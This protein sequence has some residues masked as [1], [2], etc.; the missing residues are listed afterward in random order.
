MNNQQNTFNN[1]PQIGQPLIPSPPPMPMTR[2][3]RLGVK[4]MSGK[5]LGYTSLPDW[6]AAY[7]VSAYALTLIG[8][9]LVYS[10]YAMEWY[11]WLFG[12]VW[13]AGFF[14][15][16]VKFNN[17]WSAR[18]L[19]NSK[20]FEKKIFGTGLAL[21][22]VYAIF[23]YY[24]YTN[25]TGRPHE[26][27]AADSSEYVVTA[28]WFLEE[29]RA[30]RF[31]AMLTEMSRSAMGDMGYPLCLM[32]P[33]SIVGDEGAVWFIQVIQAVVGAYTA[34]LVY[35]L[36]KRSMGEDVAR[37]AAIFCM[38][39]PILICYIGMTLKETIM[40]CLVVL[41][42]EMGDRMLRKRNY[43]FI[44]IAPLVLVGLSL[45]LFRTVIGMIVFMALFF[46]LV[47]MDSRIV[48]WGKKIA[49]GIM[50]TGVLFMAASESIIN[51]ID[52]INFDEAQSQQETSLE[53]RYGEKKSGGRGN[54]FA[55][56]AGTAVFAPLIFTI[57]F[58][59]MV[60]TEGQEDMRLIHGGN[61]MRN[62]TSGLVI[63]AMFMLLLTGDWRKFTL[64]LAMLL[65]Y[66]MMLSF[67]QFAHSLRFHIP[68]M[69][70]EMMFAAY[71]ITNMREKHK[72][73][74]LIWCMLCV[75]MS[76]AWNWFKLAGRGLM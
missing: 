56:Y 13:V 47:M 28:Q 40:T 10:N 4:L 74:Y 66:L 57:P 62:V 39:H 23:I 1:Q 52:K 68:V 8:V 25:M 30:D 46:A 14:F 54:S 29:W 27:A 69:P 42:I 11:F 67:T 21:R 58:P 16:S 17:E 26:F 15:L 37:M 18:R 5:A 59:T 55:K 20:S 45:F 73:W 53:Y 60:S 51:E 36:A 2:R 7:A 48:S 31:W 65:G 38:L 22:V 43:T 9:N 49:L 50:I 72:N 70:F 75:V 71:A 3:A 44:T 19:R 12:I 61:W 41:F 24:F 6:F 34:V 32:L 63:L 35:R 33:L 64:P 76:F